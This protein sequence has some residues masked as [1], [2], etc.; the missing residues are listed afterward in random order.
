M[1]IKYDNLMNLIEKNMQFKEI[2]KSKYLYLMSM[3]TSVVYL[4][5]EN[6]INSV[7]KI[8]QNGLI[9]VAYIGNICDFSFDIIGSGTVF[10]EQKIIH[11]AKSVGHIED[12]VVHNK[13]R[14]N[15]IAKIIVNKP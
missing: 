12:I 15:G 7:K 5:T 9:Y 13:Y 14:G 11:D 2:I 3:L 1:E 6:F 8:S 4:T 10:I